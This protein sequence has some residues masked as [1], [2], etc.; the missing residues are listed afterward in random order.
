KFIAESAKFV[1]LDEGRILSF[2]TTTEACQSVQ[3][4]IKKGDLVLI[5][6]SRAVG[7]EK[8]VEEIKENGPVV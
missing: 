4:L 5:K 8:V 1:G 2:D 6:A 3:D 7:L